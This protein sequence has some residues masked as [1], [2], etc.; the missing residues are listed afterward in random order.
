MRRVVNCPDCPVGCSVVLVFFGL[1][2][3]PPPGK[4][5]LRWREQDSNLRRHGRQIYSLIPLTA[6]V[7]LRKEAS[8]ELSHKTPPSVKLIHRFFEK[9]FPP[10]F[11]RMGKFARIADETGNWGKF[12]EGDSGEGIFLHFAAEWVKMR[13]L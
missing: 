7:S 10:A 4:A 9:Y 2:S 3:F 6:R 11:W 8:C 5:P 1:G 12:A 13:L